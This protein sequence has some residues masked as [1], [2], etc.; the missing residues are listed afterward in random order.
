MKHGTPRRSNRPQ[1]LAALWAQ[2]GNN[3]GTP[4]SKAALQ[5]K[6]K[7]EIIR[8]IQGR[9]KHTQAQMQIQAR[10]REAETAPTPPTT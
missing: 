7:G 2:L 9:I 8:T 4:I 1:A 10:H 5:R 3:T 6:R